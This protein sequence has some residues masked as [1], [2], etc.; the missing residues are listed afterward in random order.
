MR[1]SR[2]HLFQLCWDMCKSD[3]IGA[4]LWY[5]WLCAINHEVTAVGRTMRTAFR[6]IDLRW[7]AREADIP[8]A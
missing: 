5:V 4:H 6:D 2:Q 8:N 7:F 3:W 1:D